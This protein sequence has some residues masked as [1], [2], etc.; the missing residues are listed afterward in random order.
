MLKTNKIIPV[1]IGY[2]DLI[3]SRSENSIYIPKHEFATYSSYLLIH[4]VELRKR[5]QKYQR[6]QIN[7][8]PYILLNILY[9]AY[10][11]TR[12]SLELASQN[13][14]N[15]VFTVSFYSGL[16]FCVLEVLFLCAII[17]EIYS[18][19]GSSIKTFK[20]KLCDNIL[21]ENIE[22]LLAISSSLYLGLFLIARTIAG[23]CPEE[24]DYFEQSRCN[25]SALINSI[26]FD[27][28]VIN[29]ISIVASLFAFR[30]VSWFF[31]LVSF[32]VSFVSFL[33][34]VSILKD[35]D[36]SVWQGVFFIVVFISAYELERSRLSEFFNTLLCNHEITKVKTYNHTIM[37]YLSHEIRSPLNII[38]GSSKILQDD[39]ESNKSA[40]N[41]IQDITNAC[42]YVLEI[43]DHFLIFDGLRSDKIHIEKTW[44]QVFPTLY[45]MIDHHRNNLRERKVE[46]SIEDCIPTNL[47]LH[48]YIDE[49]KIEKF[50]AIF[51][52]A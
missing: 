1:P 43:L 9:V 40:I 50:C 18:P 27:Q 28:Y 30:G 23:K 19:E 33:I 45:C 20:K 47:E 21:F 3:V 29:L 17:I 14:L 4:D 49:T 2:H 5:Y 26:P 32:L 38:S 12:G 13:K 10:F 15:I 7:F 39:L 41:N 44:L 6:S 42:H 36:H 25:Y 48:F 24:F 8:I 52:R 37:R 46:C 51:L 31:I 35:F 22:S 11:I 34:S 16:V